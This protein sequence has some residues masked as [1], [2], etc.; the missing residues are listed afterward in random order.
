[1]DGTAVQDRKTLPST[2]DCG[3]AHGPN[4]DGRCEWCA[5]ALP[6]GQTVWCSPACERGFREAHVWHSARLAARRR[7]A[8]ACEI[9]RARPAQ[10]HHKDP[11]DDY[12]PGCQ[13]HADNLTMRCKAHHAYEH[14]CL[15]AKP[16]TQLDF[17]IAA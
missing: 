10:V 9:C 12:G 8:G 13:H 14:R 2:A 1:M 15:R 7:T 6:D 11:V 5:T 4:D 17:G 3:L 16:G